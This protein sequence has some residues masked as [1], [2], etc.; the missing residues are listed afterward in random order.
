MRINVVADALRALKNAERK[1]KKQ[2]LLRPVSKILLKF[3][4]VM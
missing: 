3:L 4:R 1:G 2:V